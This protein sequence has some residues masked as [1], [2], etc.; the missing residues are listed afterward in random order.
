MFPWLLLLGGTYLAYEGAEKVWH[1]IAAKRGGHDE[2]DEPS[3]QQSKA[4]DYESSNEHT[5]E[6][7]LERTETS[8][9]QIVASAVRTDLVLST[10]IMLIS[11]ANIESPS[12]G[13]RLATLIA[14]AAI[15]TVA[16]Y[17]TVALLVK[18]DLSLIHI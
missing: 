2:H 14:V 10:E 18:M 9:K 6:E 5:V 8:E 3:D 11:L 17:G 1:W 7:V 15:M 12:W 4:L 13:L 16:V